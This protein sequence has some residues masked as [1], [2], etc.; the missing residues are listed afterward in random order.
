M[1]PGNSGMQDLLWGIDSTQ[2]DTIEIRVFGSLST[3]KNAPDRLIVD[4]SITQNN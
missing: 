3:S 4:K 1:G 2:L